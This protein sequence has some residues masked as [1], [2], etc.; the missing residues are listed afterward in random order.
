MKT[1][2]S[3]DSHARGPKATSDQVLE[4]AL[5]GFAFIAMVFEPLVYFGCLSADGV[6]V[7]AGALPKNPQG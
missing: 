4:K 2:A 5:W 1:A 3:A 7:A 6:S